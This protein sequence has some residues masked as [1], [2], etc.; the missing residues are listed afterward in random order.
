MLEEIEQFYS[1][2]GK[3]P[4]VFLIYSF[5]AILFF[6][7]ITF[8]FMIPG[9]N[10]FSLYFM[11]LTLLMYFVVANI[12]VGLFKERVWFVLMISLLLSSLGM[13]S[14]LWLE[15][16]EYSLVEYMNPTVYF[17]YPSVI[18]LIITAFY[19]ISSAVYGRK[20]D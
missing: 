6:S 5:I 18:A 19:S 13:G 17:G 10:G 14:R 8:T 7:G 1:Q 15:W 2:V 9:L 20:V 3:S 16:G 4:K 11:I 12:F